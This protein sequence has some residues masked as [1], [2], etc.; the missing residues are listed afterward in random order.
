MFMLIYV[1]IY[2]GTSESMTGLRLS[3]TIDHLRIR[4]I[5][6]SPS[7]ENDEF[8]RFFFHFSFLFFVLIVAAE[9]ERAVGAAGGRETSQRRRSASTV[10]LRSLSNCVK[11]SFPPRAAL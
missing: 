9:R 5:I 3:S 7:F 4:S 10:A 2:C 8:T 6:L 11:Y 1:C